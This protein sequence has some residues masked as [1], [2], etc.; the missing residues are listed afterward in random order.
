[1]LQKTDI[2]YVTQTFVGPSPADL[3]VGVNYIITMIN[4]PITRRQSTLPGAPRAVPIRLHFIFLYQTLNL[5]L[6]KHR[7]AVP[8]WQMTC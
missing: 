4:G 6:D 8:F 2:T 3:A 7:D 5:R 1:M